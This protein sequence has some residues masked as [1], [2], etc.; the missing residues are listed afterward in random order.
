MTPR[1]DLAAPRRLILY[2]LVDLTLI[3]DDADFRRV[4]KKLAHVNASVRSRS[5]TIQCLYQAQIRPF[6]RCVGWC[7]GPRRHRTYP[8]SSQFAESPATCLGPD[9]HRTASGILGPNGSEQRRSWL[10]NELAPLKGGERRRWPGSRLLGGP[11]APAKLERR[12]RS[13][14]PPNLDS[15]AV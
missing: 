4:G 2:N 5:R 6:R 11:N 13:P 15:S 10:I 9:A 14:A 12:A 8:Q 7:T 3:D 1:P